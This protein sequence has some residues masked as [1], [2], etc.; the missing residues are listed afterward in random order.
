MMGRRGGG[1]GARD[2]DVRQRGG[3]SDG[4]VWG[5]TTPVWKGEERISSNLGMAMLGGR[6]P[7]RGKTATALGKIRR[8]GEASGGRR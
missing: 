6:S 4:R 7:E 2:R 8:E 5:P 3:S 1:R